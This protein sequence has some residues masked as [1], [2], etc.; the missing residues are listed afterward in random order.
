MRKQWK[1]LLFYVVVLIIFYWRLQALDDLYIEKTPVLSDIKIHA[2]V[3]TKDSSKYIKEFVKYHFLQGITSMDIYDD[4][5]VPLNIKHPNIS[6]RHVHD[7]ENLLENENYYL[8]EC[9]SKVLVQHDPVD[10]FMVIDDDEFV[11]AG[12]QR[13]ANVLPR[14]SG[15]SKCIQMPVYFFGSKRSNYTGMLTMDY[16]HRERDYPKDEWKHYYKNNSK[17]VKKR[18]RK[19]IFA[20][21][22]TIQDKVEMIRNLVFFVKHG[23]LI[24]GYG[25]KC[26]LQTEIKVMHHTRSRQELESRVSNFWKGMHGLRQ[27]FDDRGKISRY[28]HERDRNEIIDRS[29]EKFANNLF[30]KDL[31]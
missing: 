4:S 14:I 23:I 6:Y 16:I 11:F 19:A 1:Y 12:K 17:G 28:F 18:I 22:K 29:L 27:R 15:E 25:V 9:F 5:E 8:V 2:C 26:K 13:L 31:Y 21:P 24:H 3:R 7:P 10:Y 30:K 20:Y